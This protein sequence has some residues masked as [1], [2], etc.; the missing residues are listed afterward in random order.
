MPLPH[1]LLRSLPHPTAC[2]AACLPHSLLRSL[3]HPTAPSRRGLAL[4]VRNKDVMDALKGLKHDL[5]SLDSKVVSLE[6]TVVATKADLAS[7]DSKVVRLEGTVASLDTKLTKLDGTVTHLQ[8][9]TRELSARCAH[10]GL[11]S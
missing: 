9:S 6:G 1:S 3:P 2:S 11:A 5:A 8:G 10:R 7:L 4:R